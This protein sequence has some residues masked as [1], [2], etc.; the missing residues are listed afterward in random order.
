MDRHTYHG[1]QPSLA[2]DDLHKALSPLSITG[3]AFAL[4]LCC[5]ALIELAGQTGLQAS[6]MLRD[7]AT[8]YDL[9]VLAGSVSVFGVMIQVATL[10]VCAMAARVLPE[11]RGLF[12]SVAFLSA[13]LALDDQFLLHE[14]ILPDSTGLPE[15]VFVAVY[16]IIG[17]L[18][19]VALWL[20]TGWAGVLRLCPAMVFLGSSVAT[21]FL[22]Q[23]ARASF[24][25]EDLLKLAGYGAWSAL[26]LSLASTLLRNRLGNADSPRPAEALR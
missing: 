21:D 23:D 8:V 22:P 20:R 2:Q 12:A 3:I 24:V 6:Q 13:L 4:V 26:W 17:L 14:R 16:P 19:L 10:G 15:P 7:P 11:W 25:V 1:Q 18:I 5:G 9:P